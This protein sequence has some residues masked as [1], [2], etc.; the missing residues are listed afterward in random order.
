MFAVFL[1]QSATW[2]TSKF[3]EVRLLLPWLLLPSSGAKWCNT[4]DCCKSE[5]PNNKTSWWSAAPDV[6]L[7]CKVIICRRLERPVRKTDAGDPVSENDLNCFYEL[8]CLWIRRSKRQFFTFLPFLSSL[9]LSYQ[10]AVITL[11]ATHHLI[12]KEEEGALSEQFYQKKF[13]IYCN[14]IITA[15]Y[16]ICIKQMLIIYV[17]FNFIRFLSKSLTYFCLCT[18]VRSGTYWWRVIRWQWP[19]LKVRI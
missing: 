13:C 17:E 8:I 12:E 6:K 7:R 16:L 11:V 9:A 10:V 4:P 2:S 1:A 18:G 5:A 15:N 14:N 19:G 3:L